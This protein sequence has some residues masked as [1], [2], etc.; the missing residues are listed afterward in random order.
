MLSPAQLHHALEVTTLDRL[1][2]STDYPFQRPTRED[3][4]TFLGELPTEADRELFT[5]GNAR[6]LFGLTG[7]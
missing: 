6:A 4:A 2:F 5:S 3:I 1:L 7:R